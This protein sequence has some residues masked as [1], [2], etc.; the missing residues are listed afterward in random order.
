M[1][2]W[3]VMRYTQGRPDVEIAVVS[4]QAQADRVMMSQPDY[5]YCGAFPCNRAHEVTQ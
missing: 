3:H 4:T 2:H 1:E 5:L